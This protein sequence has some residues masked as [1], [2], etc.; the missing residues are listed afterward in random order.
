MRG[1]E[2]PALGRREPSGA[3]LEASKIDIRRGAARSAAT[4]RS[5]V[6]LQAVFFGPLI[7][8]NLTGLA[9]VILV[10][11]STQRSLN[12]LLSCVLAKLTTTYVNKH[13][14]LWCAALSTTLIVREEIA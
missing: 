5:V 8:A 6:Y 1:R 7:G 3:R 14:F 11:P 12:I 10:L 2:A 9:V 4:G 13:K